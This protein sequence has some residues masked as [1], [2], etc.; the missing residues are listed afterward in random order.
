MH[1]KRFLATCIGCFLSFIIQAQT[2]VDTLSLAT[3][4]PKILAV[5]VKGI[6]C[7][8]D[9]ITIQEN[10][11]KLPGIQAC[12]PGKA[13]ATTRFTISFNPALVNEKA[14]FQAIENTPGCEDAK[15]RPYKVKQQ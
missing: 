11:Q 15:D 6:T 14:I 5:K 2:Q 1:S 8:G 9:L 7:A 12:E 3:Q 4:S 10:I 13:S